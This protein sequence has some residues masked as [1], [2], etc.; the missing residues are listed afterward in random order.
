M[1]KWIRPSGR[2]IETN[3]NEETVTYCESLGWKRADGSENTT[4]IST[5]E[6]PKKRRRRRNG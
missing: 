6:A 1:I 2:E 5:P 4:Q 3:D